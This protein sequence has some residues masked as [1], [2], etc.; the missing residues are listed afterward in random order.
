[1]K[2]ARLSISQEYLRFTI[3]ADGESLTEELEK[4]FT[5]ILEGDL[6]A[7][8]AVSSYIRSEHLDTGAEESPA[9]EMSRYPGTRCLVNYFGIK[10]KPSLRRVDKMISSLRTAELLHAPI[11]MPFTFDYLKA[12]HSHLFGDI[13][14]SAGMIRRSLSSKHTEFCQPEYIESQA[15]ILFSKLRDDHYLSRIDDV[16]DFVNE[17]A[18][19]MGEMEALH[20]FMD[21]NGRATRFFFNSLALAAGYEIGWGSADPDH[22]LEANV[23]ALDGDY[24]AL[25]DVLE[26]IVI[27]LSND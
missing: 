7:D 17:L 1:M 15:G 20:P 19:Y 2:S 21:G 27:P 23:A 6:S 5:D 22:F 24:Q 10:D 11:D 13:Y 3:E 26:E 4:T 18:Y 8:I 14:P 12:I 16:D 9:D 25:M